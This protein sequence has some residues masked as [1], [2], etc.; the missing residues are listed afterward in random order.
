MVR[1]EVGLL[2][3]A[4]PLMR[5]NILGESFS[6]VAAVL[7][8]VAFMGDVCRRQIER[9]YTVPMKFWT[10]IILNTT[11]W[12]YIAAQS[13][14]TGIYGNYTNTLKATV[15]HL[16]IVNPAAIILSNKK[17]NSAFFRG[18]I[19]LS[20]LLILSYLLSFIISLVV[21]W[22][23]M[24]LFQFP[25]ERADYAGKVYFPFTILYQLSIGYLVALPRFQGFAREAGILQCYL[26]W[27]FFACE[28]FKISRWYIK[29]LLVVGIVGTF[30]T[31]GVGLFGV[32]YAIK[33]FLK[34]QFFAFFLI[35]ILGAA[36]FL[37]APLIGISDKG[38]THGSSI[39]DRNDAIVEG[40]DGFITNP[41]G[42]GLYTSNTTRE[43]EGINLVGL[44]PSIGFVGVL[45]VLAIYFVPL[46]FDK[47]QRLQSFVCI[48][49]IFLTLLLSQ[50]ILDA[51]FIYMIF[52][53]IYGAPKTVKRFSSNHSP[54]VRNKYALSKY[55]TL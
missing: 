37:Y 50:P 17:C 2:L 10:I 18:L 1:M 15:L 3:L 52:M 43:N 21:S 24:Y 11:L 46:Y 26:I 48:S 33:M 34:G 30:S 49:P 32:V 5:P 51:P 53:A 39:K 29:P 28:Y 9:D 8:L 13:T 44:F 47:E 25:M 42:T 55:G 38:T 16:F 40:W 20:V 7:V 14:L 19:F 4:M 23:R 31:I 12:L 35:G 45:L 6:A 22:D 36:T 41:F 27:A 54:A